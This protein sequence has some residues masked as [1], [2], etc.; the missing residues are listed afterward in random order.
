MQ[1]VHGVPTLCH[2]G[3]PT[4]VLTSRT[5]DNPGRRF[6]RCGTTFGPGHVFKWVDE[7]TSEE[8]ARIA[9]KQATLEEDLIQVKE[10]LLDIKKDIQEIVA[11]LQAMRASK[12]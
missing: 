7:A 3:S 11:I 12:V 4:I 9:D 1:N 6:F 10:D 8:L 2:C 5:Q